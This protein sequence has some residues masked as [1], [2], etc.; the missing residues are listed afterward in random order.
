MMMN[1]SK[2]VA[3]LLAQLGPLERLVDDKR[4]DD[5]KRLDEFQTFHL[6]R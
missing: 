5:A 1:G 6:P 3:A 4:L 2:S